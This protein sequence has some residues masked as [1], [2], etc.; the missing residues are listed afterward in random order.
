M[1][2][3]ASFNLHAGVD[4]YGRRFDHVTACAELEADVLVL[5][6]V[7]APL[8][9][10]SQAAEIAGCLGY[11]LKELALSRAFR[12]SGEMPAP[13]QA[14]WEPHRPYSHSRRAIRV[15]GALQASDPHLDGYDEGTWGI[16]ILTR[17]EICSDSVI[18]LGRL[19]R[20]FT[21][22][23]ALSVTLADGL[24]VVGTHMAHSTHGSPLHFAKLY[25]ALP[26]RGE[27]AVLAGD[28]NF[29]GPP[30]ELALPGWRRA[31]K[32]KTW[33][34]WRPRHQLDHIFVTDALGCG[35][36]R[37]VRAGNSDHLPVRTRISMAP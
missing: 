21:A 16:A 26:S 37:A 27:P 15:G 22:R 25:R 11:Q 10:R 3:V 36:D 20:D 28:M 13:E 29:W 30:I 5:Q 35:S 31:V 19:R 23:A 14:G 18:S 6:E 12:V 32:A 1:T 4:G 17:G 34:S 7:F 33:P 2:V 8:K 24:T 9:G